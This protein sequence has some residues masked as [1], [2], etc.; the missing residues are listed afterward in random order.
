MLFDDIVDVGVGEA[1]DHP[2][3][4]GG[5]GAHGANR[6]AAQTRG[7]SAAPSAPAHAHKQQSWEQE[8]K[9]VLGGGKKAGNKLEKFQDDLLIWLFVRI[10]SAITEKAVLFVC[11]DMLKR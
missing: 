4:G 10:T 11:Y 9:P 8:A 2:H 1:A 3:W 5:A 7:G 6:H